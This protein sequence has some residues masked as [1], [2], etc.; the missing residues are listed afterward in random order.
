MA[1][2]LNCSVSIEEM[3]CLETPTAFAS[4]PC[5][6]FFSALAALSRFLNLSSVFISLPQI[7]I[8]CGG[9]GCNS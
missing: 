1:V 3:V 7:R 9:K 4:S 6:R 2:G 5:E 8:D